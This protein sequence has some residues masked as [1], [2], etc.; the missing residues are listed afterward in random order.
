MKA[1]PLPRLSAAEFIDWAAAQTGNERYEL[2]AG[3]VVAMSP[4]RAAHGRAKANVYV[5]L[6]EAIG[7]AALGCEAFVDGMSVRIDDAT[8]YEPDVLLRCGEPLDDDALLV[9]D[10]LLIVEVLS[11]SSRARDAGAKLEDYFRLESVRH[12]L[13]VKTENRAVIHHRRSEDGG[14]QTSILRDGT[15]RLDPPGLTLEVASFFARA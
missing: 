6:R 4:E 12:Y 7:A 15:L 11:P 14:I 13:I 1:H 2:A 5:A 3:Q 8:V 10:P 9:D